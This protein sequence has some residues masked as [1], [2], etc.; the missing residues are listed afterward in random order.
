MRLKF[1]LFLVFTFASLA[2]FSSNLISSAFSNSVLVEQEGKLFSR[3]IITFGSVDW[4]TRSSSA[5]IEVWISNLPYNYSNF[6]CLVEN[7]FYQTEESGRTRWEGGGEARFSLEQ[8]ERRG[9]EGLFSYVAKDVSVTLRRWGLVEFYPFDVHMVNIT[10]SLPNF[11]LINQDNSI[12]IV[13]FIGETGAEWKGPFSSVVWDKETAK[14]NLNYLFSRG[15]SEVGSFLGVI[16]V[17]YLLL[18]ST[19]LIDPEKLEHRLTICLTLF[20]F[21]ISFFSTISPPIK[22][23][24]M[25]LGEALVYALL[26]G[27]GMFAVASVVE[28]ALIDVK[29]RLKVC[30]YV[31][32]GFFLLITIATLNSSFVW[33]LEA[34]RGSP[35]QA[36]STLVAMLSGVLAI[37]LSYGYVSKT[38]VFAVRS[39]RKNRA[40]IS[41]RI[42]AIRLF[43]RKAK[44]G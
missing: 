38:L 34:L 18:G 6:E 28:K 16:M 36:N 5:N 24:R 19:P 43:H 7:G 14:L 39:L 31:L 21:S 37:P 9:E 33:F 13:S 2:V 35:W 11:G 3:F 41:K 23:F 15:S 30:Q 32:D 22:T 8:L 10:F 42:K 40:Q 44:G 29:P 25:S 4:G 12:A 27:T 26:I 17:C 1:G 20:I